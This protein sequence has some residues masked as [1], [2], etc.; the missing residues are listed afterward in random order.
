DDD[1]ILYVSATEYHKNKAQ[2][3]EL[4]VVILKAEQKLLETSDLHQKIKLKKSFEP[5][6]MRLEFF[7]EFVDK[8]RIKEEATYDPEMPRW[9]NL[10]AALNRFM[11]GSRLTLAQFTNIKSNII[12]SLKTMY[13]SSEPKPTAEDVA[14][15]PSLLQVP[16]LKH[17]K[18]ALRWMMF[19]ERQKISGGILADDMGLGKTLSMIALVLASME[20][21]WRKQ[22]EKQ[23][24]QQAM[25]IQQLQLTVSRKRFS[26]F[27]DEDDDEDEEDQKVSLPKRLC[28]ADEFPDSDD[29]EYEKAGHYQECGTL[30]VCPMSVMAQWSMEVASKVAPGRLRVLTFHGQD[31][32]TVATNL[33]SYDMVI[34]SYTTVGTELRIFGKKSMLFAPHWNR[35]ILDEA[36]TIR[37]ET[38]VSSTA[39]CRL[40][41]TSRWALTGTPIQ[42]GAKDVFAL[43]NFLKVPMIPDLLQWTKYLRKEIRVHKILRFIIK[44]LMIRRTKQLLQ[45]SREIPLLPPRDDLLIC[46]QLSEQEMVVYQILSAI[47]KKVFYQLLH[48]RECGNGDLNYYTVKNRPQFIEDQFNYKYTDIYHQ[49]LASLGYN[50]RE[51]INGIVMLVLLLRLRQFCC[52][53]GLMVQ[54]LCSPMSNDELET[55]KKDFEGMGEDPLGMEVLAELKKKGGASERN[56][57]NDH[58]SESNVTINEPLTSSQDDNKDLKLLH[59]SNPIYSFEFSSAKLTALMEKLEEVLDNTNDKIVVASQWVRFLNLIKGR[60]HVLSWETLEF[61]GLLNATKREKVLSE[62]CTENNGKRILLLSL[63]T[64]GVGLNLNVANHMFL[65]DLHWNPHLEMQAQDRIYRYGQK[66]PTFTYR[67]V[68]KDTVEERI[69]ALQ[70]YKLEVARVVLPEK[71]SIITRPVRGGNGLSFEELR[72]LFDV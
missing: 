18:R 46:V 43:L 63:T 13:E 42:N 61:T 22:E 17:Q 69:R 41:A 67:F 60:L 34:T 59:P 3:D 53:P 50:P 24:A 35:V 14:E 70:D 29:D 65:V 26:L 38:T 10:Y 57:G 19:R 58:S 12:S 51:K 49:F 68:C 32:H 45:D 25:W 20:P 16:L 39:V 47:S 11:D 9:S 4:V 40:Q 55:I 48:Q 21:K 2:M 31:R 62:F 72:K 54:L 6:I 5:F 36:H 66:K 71:E 44:P 30:V 52:H 33:R 8:M 64:G 15:Q 37:N 28:I 27:D 1:D 23:R 7:T 56:A